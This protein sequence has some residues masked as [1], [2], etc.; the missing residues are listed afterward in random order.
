MDKDATCKV[1]ESVM[2]SMTEPVMSGFLDMLE[3]TDSAKLDMLERMIRERK[4]NGR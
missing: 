2:N 1:L 4:E 3:K